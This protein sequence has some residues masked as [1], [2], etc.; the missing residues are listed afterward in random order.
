MIRFNEYLTRNFYMQYVA[1]DSSIYFDSDYDQQQQQR[2]CKSL[3]VSLKKNA[4]REIESQDSQ[5]RKKMKGTY[6]PINFDFMESIQDCPST[7]PVTGKPRF[8]D[9]TLQPVVRKTYLDNPSQNKRLY[10]TIS[11]SDMV[12]GDPMEGS[13]TTFAEYYMKRY[14]R[15]VDPNSCLLDV[16]PGSQSVTYHP[17][18]QEQTKANNKEGR[19]EKLVPG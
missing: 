9:A 11:L 3:V 6:Q 16:V 18:L 10:Y 1:E 5:T 4:V 17:Q 12:A 19:K 14:T 15:D 7:D 2:T 13:K 8:P